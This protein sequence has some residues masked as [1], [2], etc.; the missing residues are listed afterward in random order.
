METFL[1]HPE[2]PKYLIGTSGTIISTVVDPAGRKRKTVINR[3]GYEAVILARIGQ[4]NVTK[5][6]HRLV[7][8]THIP[9]PLGLPEV[10]HIDHNKANNCAS[11]LEWVTHRENILKGHAFNGDW[12]RKTGAKNAKPVVATP[13]SGGEPQRWPSARAWAI[14]SGNAHRAANVSTA[15]ITGGPAYGF[16]WAFDQQ[17]E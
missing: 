3:L 8:Q 4:P 6:V 16:T 15:I 9:N 1:P 2:F 13:I 7:A 12:R 17:V 11:N 10:N 14:Q 5:K